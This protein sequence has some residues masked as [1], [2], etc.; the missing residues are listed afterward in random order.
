MS[1]VRLEVALTEKQALRYAM[2]ELA[3]RS[4]VKS[5]RVVE[6]AQLF[7]EYLNRPA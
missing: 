6:D 5:E 3:V 1:D 2:L 7:Y 4:G